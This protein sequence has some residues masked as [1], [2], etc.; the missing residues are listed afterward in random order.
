MNPATR[1]GA[2]RCGGKEGDR[3]AHPELD[4]PDR[5]VRDEQ[6]DRDGPKQDITISRNRRTP[7]GNPTKELTTGGIRAGVATSALLSGV[8]GGHVP[9]R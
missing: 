1:V 6:G 8:E 3:D 9:P 7:D 5:P 4:C 2:G